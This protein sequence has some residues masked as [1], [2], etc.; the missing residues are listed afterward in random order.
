M[1]S[2]GVVGL[3]LA[4]ALGGPAVACAQPVGGDPQAGASE[5]E[6]SLT[7]FWRSLGDTTL[8][9]LVEEAV[10]ANRNVRA[11]EAR[12]RGADADRVAAALDLT[13]SISATAGYTR[14]RFSRAAIPGAVGPFPDQ[15]VWEAGVELAWE[16]DAFGRLRNRLEGR[17]LMV[18]AAED[19]ARAVQ[20]AVAADLAQAYFDLRGGQGRLAVAR[21]NAENQRSTLALTRDRLEAGTGTALDMERA[22]AQLSSTLAELP[23]LEAAV[24]ASHNRIAVLVGREPASLEQELEPDASLPLPE[25]VVVHDRR[26]AARLRPDVQ[27]AESRLEAGR[28]LASSA[29][30]AY[31]PTVSLGG[32]AGYTAN[33][34]DALG[35]SGTPRF[36]L[37]AVVSWP[38]LDLGRVKAEA[39]Q[40]RAYE[41]EAGA[42]HEQ[43]LLEAHEEIQT[44]LASYRMARKRLHHLEEAAA[45]SERAT[46][47]AR[48]RFEEGGTDFLEVLDAERRQLEAQDRLALGRVE[49]AGWLVSVYRATGGRSRP[50]GG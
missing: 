20:L 24:T 33:A 17:D 7:T 18:E 36:A 34:F 22:Q 23:A 27:G 12:T 45:A 29:R 46:D 50:E 26:R 38:F 42:R 31:L 41:V 40:A 39:D 32:V 35:E 28:A 10:V 14:Q 13:P 9:R 21:R 30:A 25:E 16:V 37:G 11:S 3:A 8:G 2:A 4:L 19:D 43:A 15:D 5:Q 6:A 1:R 44:S 48:L 47:L 49:A